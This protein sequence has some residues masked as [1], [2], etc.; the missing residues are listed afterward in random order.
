MV[1]LI[2]NQLGVLPIEFEGQPP[3]LIDPNCVVAAQVA[4]QRMESPAGPIHVLR[5]DCCIELTELQAKSFRVFRL[6][7][8]LGAG[9]KNRSMPL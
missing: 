7:A 2:V 1:V 3:V 5:P 4:L 8:S 6:D 9:A